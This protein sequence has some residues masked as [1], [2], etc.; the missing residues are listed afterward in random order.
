MKILL[1]ISFI[2]P[3]IINSQNKELDFEYFL[4]GVN[5][6]YFEYGNREFKD[7][8]VDIFFEALTKGEIIAEYLKKKIE[9]DS[10]DYVKIKRIDRGPNFM[11]NRDDN[12]SQYYMY[13]KF[14][15]KG[16]AENFPLTQNI[17]LDFKKKQAYSFITGAYLRNG[18]KI[19]DTIYKISILTSS[20]PRYCYSI[21]KKTNSTNVVYKI[22]SQDNSKKDVLI[23]PNSTVYFNPSDELKEHLKIIKDI[24][25][26]IERYKTYLSEIYVESIVNEKKRKNK[27]KAEN[28]LLNFKATFKENISKMNIEDIDIV[29]QLL[30]EEIE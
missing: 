16:L 12:L 19:N 11:N 28:E 29:K 2:I 10:I 14:L 8:Q 26:I 18:Y 21:L 9:K 23:N 15:E 20:K 30:K 5:H 3:F 6:C 1:Y 25:E 24:P 13:S 17:E 4:Y 22:K 7:N 27:V